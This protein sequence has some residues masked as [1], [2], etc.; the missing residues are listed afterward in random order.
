MGSNKDK[1]W[2]FWD[3]GNAKINKEYYQLKPKYRDKG[4]GVSTKKGDCLAEWDALLECY[5][6]KGFHESLCPENYLAVMDCQES[7]KEQLKLAR[8][9]NHKL[10]RITARPLSHFTTIYFPKF[11]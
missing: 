6:E 7:Q 2:G 9:I 4:A 8:A 3:D 11:K 10:R 5:T 1:K